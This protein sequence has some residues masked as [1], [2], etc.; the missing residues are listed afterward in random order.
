M[1]KQ[2]LGLLFYYQLQKIVCHCAGIYRA[3]ENVSLTASTL[4]AVACNDYIWQLMY[5]YAIKSYILEAGTF[6]DH[7]YCMCGGIEMGGWKPCGKIPEERG[8]F[9]Q[10]LHKCLTL[11]LSD[12]KFRCSLHINDVPVSLLLSICCR[13][14][15]THKG[16]QL[17]I[18]D[19]Q[20]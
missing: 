1:P 20:M 10:I 18:M 12:I 8:I 13:Y 11:L 16:K 15:D 3:V 5:F 19:P 2:D 14:T 17:I 4:S 7:S 6:S 9:S